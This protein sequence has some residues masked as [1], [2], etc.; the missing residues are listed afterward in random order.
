[1]IREVCLI[2]VLSFV[3]NNHCRSISIPTELPVLPSTV[4]QNHER[5]GDVLKREKKS[6]LSTPYVSELY[7]YSVMLVIQHKLFDDSK[8]NRRSKKN[9]NKCSELLCDLNQTPFCYNDHLT[10]FKFLYNCFVS[11]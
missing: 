3:K 7:Y 9:V 11:T 1:M 5:F 2:L 10:L 8:F 4:E 6:Y